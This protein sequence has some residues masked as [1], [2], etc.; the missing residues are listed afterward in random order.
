MRPIAVGYTLCRLAAK[1]AGRYVMDT[2]RLLLASC[3]LGYG[4]AIGCETAVHATHLYLSNLRPGQVILKLDFENAFNCIR[5]DKMLHA[6]SDLAPEFA[7][8][9]SPPTVNPPHSSGERRPSGH[10]EYNKDTH[11]DPCYT[12]SPFTSLPPSWS[13][14]SA[15]STLMM[16]PW[17]G[18]LSKSSR[19]CFL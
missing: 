6:V 7:P 5:R 9:S 1:T 4:T 3:Q 18:M 11:L 2:M 15:F 13:Q 16:G 8:L 14:N 19:A 12:A 17:G 10:Q